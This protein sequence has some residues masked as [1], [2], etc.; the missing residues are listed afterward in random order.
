MD[1]KK[2][3]TLEEKK[4]KKRNLIIALIIFTILGAISFILTE[5]P[6]LFE[7]KDNAPTSMYSDKLHSYTFYPTN[8]DLDVTADEEYMELDRRIHYK[9]GAVTVAVMPEDLA[10]YNDAVLFFVEY[11]ATVID[12]DTETYNTFFT[13]RYYETNKPYT[14]FAPQMLYDITVEQLIEEERANGGFCWVFRVDYKIHKNDGTFRNDMESDSIRTLYYQL[15]EDAQGD[16]KIDA[17]TR[18]L[19]V[20]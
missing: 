20:Q 11:F 2:T 13:D 9:K 17:I 18:Y 16:V 6:Q 4:R 12:G 8:L 7:K 19:N 15:E 5:V 3:P 14:I 10:T 1:E